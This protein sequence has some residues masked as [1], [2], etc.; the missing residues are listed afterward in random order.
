MTAKKTKATDCVCV[1][2]GKQAVAFWPC[3]DPD[4]P[5]YPYC[6]ECLDTVK[7]RVF[8]AIYDSLK[9]EDDNERDHHRKRAPE[10]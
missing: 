7:Y 4:I 8:T 2:C 5:S 9:K 10:V 3:I 1:E 6:R